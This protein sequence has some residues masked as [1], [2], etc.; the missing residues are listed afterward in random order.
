M[1][2]CLCVS[3]CVCV[4]LCVLCITI[5]YILIHNLHITTYMY[6]T[7]IFNVTQKGIR[8]LAKLQRGGGTEPPPPTVKTPAGHTPSEG[9]SP[10]GPLPARER[11]GTWSEGA[12][13]EI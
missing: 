11:T 13:G 2:V 8:S 9:P 10:T 12:G 7:T 1:C 5:R 3:V 6:F 4:C